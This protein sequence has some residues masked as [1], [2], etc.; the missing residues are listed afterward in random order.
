MISRKAITLIRSLR[1]TNPLAY[2]SGDLRDG[3]NG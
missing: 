2:G 1:G 3:S